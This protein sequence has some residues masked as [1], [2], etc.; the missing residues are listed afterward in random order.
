VS[1][2]TAVVVGSHRPGSRT[3]AAALHVARELTGAEP[4]LVVDLARLGGAL[5][6][7]DSPDEGAGVAGL[8]REVTDADLVV[9]ASPTYK[10]TYSGLLK[11]F[12]DRFAPGPGT[13]LRGVSVPVMLGASPRHALAPE[14]LLRPVLSEIGGTV[15]T[16]GLYVV[17]AEHDDPAAYRTWLDR[18]RPAVAAVL[19]LPIPSLAPIPLP[20]GAPA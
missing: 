20:T 7:V 3:L 9:F 15:V 12:L 2:R 16:P 1:A 8:V 14:L 4:D 17:D 11:V 10:A 5:L 18:A 13:G 6:E 19:G